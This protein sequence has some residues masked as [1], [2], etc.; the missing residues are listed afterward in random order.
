[1]VDNG[2][3]WNL[4]FWWCLERWNPAMFCRLAQVYI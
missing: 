3:G 4:G 2:V 1:M